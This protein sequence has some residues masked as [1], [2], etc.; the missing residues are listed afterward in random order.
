VVTT[1]QQLAGRARDLADR[2]P[3]GSLE[4]RAAGCVA[5]ALGTTR[6]IAAARKVLDDIDQ[7]DIRG[8]AGALLAELLKE[9]P[10][11]QG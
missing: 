3:R 6:S 2:A 10:D 11:G 9:E 7:A 1:N 4:R 5:V 8:R